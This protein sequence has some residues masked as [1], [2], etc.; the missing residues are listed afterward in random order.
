[1]K[2][3]RWKLCRKGMV[4]S[5]MMDLASVCRDDTFA[6]AAGGAAG[7]AAGAAAAGGG[8]G[9]VSVGQEA[10]ATSLKDALC[11]LVYDGHGG[12]RFVEGR[13]VFTKLC[14]LN[15]DPIDLAPFA[16]RLPA[17]LFFGGMGQVRRGRRRVVTCY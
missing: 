6:L 15:G 5:I 14:M 3:R 10:I 13:R 12:A 11:V 9:F 1:M 17:S 7:G 2:I 8:G 4:R 16:H